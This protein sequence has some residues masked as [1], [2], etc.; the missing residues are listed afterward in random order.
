[1]KL[2]A[3]SDG[4]VSSIRAEAMGQCA[5]HQNEE[6]MEMSR[7]TLTASQ[8]ERA[9]ATAQTEQQRLLKAAEATPRR[10]RKMSRSTVWES[11][12]GGR[13]FEAMLKSTAVDLIDARYLIA[14]ARAG[15]K[16][17][18]WQEVPAAAKITKERLWWLRGWNH[19]YKL[20]VLVL[21]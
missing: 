14:L 13:S 6:E 12:C 4:P 11:Y 10:L 19:K 17:P 9:L 20:P 3:S 7:V 15:G 18:R 21:S 16:M 2:L 1:M 8:A 5:E